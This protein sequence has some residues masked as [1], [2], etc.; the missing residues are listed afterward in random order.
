MR[1]LI[2]GF[3]FAIATLAQ[4]EASTFEVPLFVPSTIGNFPDGGGIGPIYSFLQVNGL[5]ADGFVS[6]TI[7]FEASA[8]LLPI[9]DPTP[10]WYNFNALVNNAHVPACGNNFAGGSYCRYTIPAPMG[11]VAG[12]ADSGLPPPFVSDVLNI[13][14]Q[15]T[16]SNVTN[17]QAHLFITLPDGITLGVPEPSTWAMLL[18]GF[19]AIG[20]AAYRRRLLPQATLAN[21]RSPTGH[22]VHG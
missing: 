4:A 18:I 10:S 16:A 9:F 1:K 2:I 21:D 12:S 6:F 14:I 17:L 3:C 5:A 7:D 8:T 15:G 19:V 22:L 13:V 11:E 20:F